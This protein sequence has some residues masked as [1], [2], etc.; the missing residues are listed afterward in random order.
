MLAMAIERGYTV[1][2]GSF[3]GARQLVF[4]VLLAVGCFT[5]WLPLLAQQRS[6]DLGDFLLLVV[7]TAPLAAWRLAP[8]TVFVLPAIA[9]IGLAGRGEVLWPPI[10]PCVA[11][12]LLAAS[13]EDKSRWNVHLIAASVGLLVIYL[14]VVAAGSRSVSTDLGHAL[15]AGAVAWFAGERTRLRRQQLLD[16]HDRMRRAEDSAERD[17]QLALAKERTQIAR[18]LQNRP[19]LTR[20]CAA[21]LLCRSRAIWVRSWA[22]A[23][24]RSRSAESS[25]R[26]IWSCRSRS[27]WGAWCVP[28]RTRRPRPQAARGRGRWTPTRASCDH[29]EVED[30]QPDRQPR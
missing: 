19:V 9:A 6:L 10:G 5:A 29:A 18:D 28:R 26:R 15:L 8:L 25:A 12:Y 1:R 30:K 23:S 20:C 24:C 7:A 21:S 14:G 3:V 4:D 16:L 11:L 13:R 2:R 27:C 22:T 17:L